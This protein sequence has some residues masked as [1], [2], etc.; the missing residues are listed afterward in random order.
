M[1]R[2]LSE[3]FRS[4]LLCSALTLISCPLTDSHPAS[5]DP[6]PAAVISTI[7][8]DGAVGAAVT[9]EVSAV[10]DMD[11][12][13]SSFSLDSFTLRRDT[14]STGGTVAYDP[15]S[16][17]ASFTSSGYLEPDAEYTATISTEVRDAAGKA[18]SADVEWR[19]TTAAAGTVAAPVFDP[20]EGVFENDLI[21]TIASATPDALVYYTME[22]GTIASPPSDPADPTTSSTAYTGG[23]A[24]AG[25]KTMVKIRAI[26]VKDGMSD[27]TIASAQYTVDACAFS[28]LWGSAVWDRHEWNP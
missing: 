7:P 12:T 24:V 1:M 10:F 20:P 19:F 11:M 6:S 26:A 5:N 4:I 2:N 22:S 8:S 14:V 18:L 27:S 15:A 13:G 3:V 21:A 23:I 16:R 28:A 17:T 9:A 25:Q